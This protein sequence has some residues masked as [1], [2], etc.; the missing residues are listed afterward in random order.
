M[1]SSVSHVT[2]HA[3]DELAL[4]RALV[5]LLLRMSER[6]AIG[7]EVEVRWLLRSRY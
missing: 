7:L 4:D 1:A 5:A 6:G 2:V 3:I